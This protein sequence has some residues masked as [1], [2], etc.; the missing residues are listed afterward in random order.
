LRTSG[1]YGVYRIGTSV[2]ASGKKRLR[3]SLKQGAVAVDWATGAFSIFALTREARIGGT[4]FAVYV[5]SLPARAYLY[6]ND[7]HV[8]FTDVPGLVANKHDLVTW[9]LDSLP[10]LVSPTPPELEREYSF[11]A[12]RLSGG[13][14]IRLRVALVTGAVGAG[15]IAWRIF[16]DNGRRR[17]TVVVGLPL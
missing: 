10:H 2:D 12:R 1:D 14:N 4:T 11:Y 13:P 15:Y 3:L 16:R 5:D 9:T 17:G 7:G 8:E 6:V